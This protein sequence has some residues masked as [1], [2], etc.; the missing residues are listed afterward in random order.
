LDVL[1]ANAGILGDMQASSSKGMLT[2]LTAAAATAQQQERRPPM[3]VLCAMFRIFWY[4]LFCVDD[5]S[6]SSNSRNTNHH[7]VVLFLSRDA[8]LLSAV[9]HLCVVC[10]L[11]SW[12]TLLQFEQ[13]PNELC[14]DNWRNIFA[15]NVDGVF[16]TVRAAYPL[17]KQSK[18]SKVVITSSIA[19]EE[20]HCKKRQLVLQQCP[21][22][23]E[24]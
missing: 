20:D 21:C 9:Y 19:G 8:S 17:L 11:P 2:A 5:G 15:T 6:S 18:H 7:V 13:K 1:I 24:L 22:L 16:H 4:D 23:G 3:P 12:S 14:E 10:A